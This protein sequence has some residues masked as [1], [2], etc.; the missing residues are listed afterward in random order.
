MILSN[1]E[2]DDCAL[3]SLFFA[4]LCC[5]IVVSDGANVK[6]S[7]FTASLL[8]ICITLAPYPEEVFGKFERLFGAYTVWRLVF[9][10]SLMFSLAD[11]TPTPEH[12]LIGE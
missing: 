5:E 10:Q 1:P 3:L 8:S 4:T 11:S 2:D 6:R 9:D 7:V 12:G